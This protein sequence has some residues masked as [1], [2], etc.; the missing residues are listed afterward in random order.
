MI[1]VR[2]GFILQPGDAMPPVGD[3]RIVLDCE[4]KSGDPRV[5]A[6]SPWEGHRIA[7]IAYA[8]DDDGP[9][10]YLP[11]RQARSTNLPIERVTTWA[12]DVMRRA[13][14]WCNHNLKFDAHFL[15]AD[16]V[17]PCAAVECTLTMAKLINSERNSYALDALAMD[18]LGTG[19][20]DVG[21][22]DFLRG[23]KTKDF[24]DLPLDIIG[25]HGCRDVILNRALRRRLDALLP[26]E[27]RRIWEIEQRVTLALFDMERAG[28][29]VNPTEL[30]VTA[31]R[32]MSRL[33]G[34]EEEIATLAGSA[35]NPS[36]NDDCYG[37][38]CVAHGLPVMGRTDGGDPSFDAEALTHYSHLPEVS[39]SLA[40]SRLV[41]LIAAHREIAVLLHT[42]V[43]PYTKLQVGGKLHPFYNQAVRTGRMSCKHPNA[44]QLSEEA[45]ALIHPDPGH[46]FLSCDYSQIEFRII[47]HY[48]NN[49]EAVRAYNENPDTDYHTWVAQLCGIPRKPAKN[50]NFAM[51]Y[52]AGR[53]KV[54]RMLSQ[55]P[56]L[57][58]NILT[59][60]DEAIAAGRIPAEQRKATLDGL[61]KKQGEEVYRR[62][63]QRLPEL[64]RVSSQAARN[65]ERRGYVFNGYGRRRHL[66]RR[67]S[68]RGLNAVAQSFAADIM[69]DRLVATAPRYNPWVKSLGITQVAV[70][71]DEVLFHG[72]T[73]VLS[74]PAV[75]RELLDTLEAPTC[76]LR[77]P[78]RCEA[79]YGTGSWA[80]LTGVERRRTP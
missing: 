78:I 8:L 35:I 15:A 36:S 3:G 16:G 18:Y 66:D 77:V 13:S 34:M 4:T 58:A 49:P 63:H 73:N 54:I 38:L 57:I 12:T 62:Y 52:G 69:K 2:D 26:D 28:M 64:R 9:A 53:P 22:R 5:S 51:G 68:Y 72:L 24:G 67:H 50:V 80:A 48:M 32:L 23:S 31:L 75:Q 56:E 27:C 44:Q 60:V 79:K 25:A 19:K 43:E 20:A 76:S 14:S 11:I 10:W 7:G 74:D 40:L 47:A 45:K 37:A 46:A 21:L 6:L 39:S 42:F 59:R 71:H 65:A 30:R 41:E 61:C 70:V 17:E 29:G 55:E 1:P 33:L